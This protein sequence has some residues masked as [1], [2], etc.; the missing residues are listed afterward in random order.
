MND[1]AH[2]ADRYLI[3]IEGGPPS[4]Y[5]AWSH[6]LPG[7]VATGERSKKPGRRCAARSRSISPACRGRRRDPGPVRPR[8]VRRAYDVDGGV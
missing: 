6:D 2:R 3:L 4:N 1:Y 8:R 5:S 7:C